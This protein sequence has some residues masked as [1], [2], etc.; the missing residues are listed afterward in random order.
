MPIPERVPL[1]VITGFL[2]AGKTSWLNRQIRQGLPPN[3]LI[4]VND[5]GSV[6]IDAQLIEYQDDR[7]LRLANGCICCTLGGTL[8]EQLAQAM[9]MAPSPEALYIEASGVAEPA[10]IADIAR[11]SRQL[12]LADVVCLVD[13]SQ[14]ACH[15]ASPYTGDVW[16][17][18]IRAAHQLHVNRLS[19]DDENQAQ[20]IACLRALNP[21]ARLCLDGTGLPARAEVSDP[22][23]ATTARHQRGTPSPSPASPAWRSVSLSYDVPIDAVQLETLF[24]QYA[25][26][27]LRAKGILARKDRAVTQVFQLSGT[28]VSWLPARRALAGN[29][30]V[31][32]GVGGER[33]EA[34]GKALARLRD[35]E[36]PA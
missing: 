13:A 9:R 28:T 34:L 32:I 4:M 5:F 20:E 15:D 23:P 12:R 17:T 29:Q 31:C 36:Q 14:I 3:S 2:G 7:I 18:Q 27:I 24:Q 16:R 25:D 8:A 30:L 22:P 26:V 6:N 19:P 21:D 10:R 33:F 1:T 11:V 35:G